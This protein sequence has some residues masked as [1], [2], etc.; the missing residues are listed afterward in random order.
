MNTANGTKII[1]HSTDW[2]YIDNELNKFEIN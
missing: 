1:L 2:V